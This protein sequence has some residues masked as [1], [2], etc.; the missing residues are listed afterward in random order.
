LVQL[1]LGA[2]NRDVIFGWG[3]VCAAGQLGLWIISD[4]EVKYQVVCQLGAYT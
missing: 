2:C 4:R 1:D 3:C